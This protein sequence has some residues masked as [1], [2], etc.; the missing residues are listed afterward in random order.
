VTGDKASCDHCPALCQQAYDRFPTCREC[1]QAICPHC[2]HPGTAEE[3]EG[4]STVICK[5]CTVTDQPC[6]KTGDGYHWPDAANICRKCGYEVKFEAFA[7]VGG[8]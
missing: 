2:A 1:D 6:D 4:R 3:D 5:R 7:E 8:L